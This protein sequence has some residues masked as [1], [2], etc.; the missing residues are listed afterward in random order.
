LLWLLEAGQNPKIFSRFFGL[1]IAHLP[2]NDEQRPPA[3]AR[4]REPYVHSPGLQSAIF[5]PQFEVLAKVALR[6]IAIDA[7]ENIE[8]IFEQLSIFVRGNLGF[9]FLR[10]S[11]AFAYILI[12]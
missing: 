6:I 12:R 9:S 7:L 3:K 8:E 1:G 10:F 5:R 4:R 2:V 11:I